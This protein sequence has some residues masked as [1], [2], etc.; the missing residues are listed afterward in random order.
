MKKLLATLIVV[1]AALL[2]A[3]AHA[4]C[5]ELC[6]LES[7]LRFEPALE[8]LKIESG[9]DT[10]NCGVR[11]SALNGCEA[12]V[13]ATPGFGY[14]A[15]AA[16]GSLP[17]SDGCDSIAPG[18]RGDFSFGLSA[19]SAAEGKE[20]WVFEHAG[21]QHT[22]EVEYQVAFRDTGCST[23]G[24]GALP[25]AAALALLGVARLLRRLPGRARR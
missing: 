24:G 12:P 10:C 11:L 13:S 1:G 19:G 5:G 20:S 15:Q 7:T 14:C 6:E 4:G 17:Q 3:R 9:E 18:Q 16:D 8:C 22:V 21:I 2:P 23:S 25:W